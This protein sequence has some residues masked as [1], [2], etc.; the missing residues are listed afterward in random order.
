MSANRCGKP[1][2]LLGRWKVTT[3]RRCG[4]LS[5]H[6]TDLLVLEQKNSITLLTKILIDI[7]VRKRSVDWATEG[8]LLGETNDVHRQPVDSFQ[9]P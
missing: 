4:W 6:A 2:P 7:F 1:V 5:I 3:L 8:M 9:C